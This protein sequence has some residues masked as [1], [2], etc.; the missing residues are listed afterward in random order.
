MNFR[1]SGQ[2]D[3]DDYFENIN[4]CATLLYIIGDLNDVLAMWSA[5]RSNFDLGCGFDI[6]FCDR[7]IYCI[8]GIANKNSLIK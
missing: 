4:L 8:N 7:G 1:N 5:K 2:K 6:Q 3:P